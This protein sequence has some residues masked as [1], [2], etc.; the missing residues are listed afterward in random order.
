MI[1]LIVDDQDV[2]RHGIKKMVN[3]MNLDIDEIYE[4]SDGQEALEIERVLK[5]DI[6]LIDIIMPRMNG[7]TLIDQL[8]KEGSKA[9]IGIIS[10]HDDFDIARKAISFKVEEYLLKPIRKSDLQL[11]LTTVQNKVNEDIKK[12]MNISE[13]EHKY[14]FRLLFDYLT[15]HDVMENPMKILNAIGVTFQHP[16][17]MIALGTIDQTMTNNLENCCHRIE[18]SLNLTGI[19]SLIFI[20]ENRQMVIIGNMDKCSNL[21]EKSIMFQLNIQQHGLQFGLSDCMEGV[22][23]L[24][25]LYEK[26]QLALKEAIFSGER[27]CKISNIQRSS[28]H[29]INLKDY[30][31]LAELLSSADKEGLDHAIDSLFFKLKN[32]NASL[33]ESNAVMSGLLNQLYSSLEILYAGLD[34][35]AACEE[36][37]STAN[38]LLQMRAIMKE[39][40]SDMYKHISEC[41][42]NNQ[43]SHIVNYLV[44]KMNKSYAEKV[45]LREMV[46]FLGMNYNY[47]SGLF[48]KKMGLTF[49]DYLLRLR[50]GKAREFLKEGTMNI[51]E[52]SVRCGFYDSKYLSKAFKKRFGVT[53]G[54]FRNKH[55]NQ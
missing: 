41:N 43:S 10:V 3:E 51:Y 45:S 27:I 20:S 1:L 44:T 53:P 42:E 13:Q 31:D 34:K 55:A 50:L 49:S 18:K 16:Y 46:D 30:L 21:F 29:V 33:Q 32:N 54:E 15:G 12:K 17:F 37:I 4:A 23:A 7:I 39:I 38:N 28:K 11:F 48:T 25:K 47:V 24:K 22:H 6:I 5:P 36:R 14:D 52:V 26:A 19:D 2:M 8:K 35:K 9:Y 40:L